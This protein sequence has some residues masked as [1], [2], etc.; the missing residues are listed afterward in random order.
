MP[1]NPA[2][3]RLALLSLLLLPPALQAVQCEVSTTSFALGRVPQSPMPSEMQSG[4]IE[5]SCFA[6]TADFTALPPSS[7]FTVNYLV[8]LS[9]SNGSF[10]ESVANRGL[11]SELKNAK[12]GYEVRAAAGC[13]SGGVMGYAG[14]DGVGC[15]GSFMFQLSPQNAVMGQTP[16][17]RATLMTQLQL[18]P[19]F[20]VPPASDYRDQL[21]VRLTY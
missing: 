15:P 5:V 11:R 12:L 9:G 3:S 19:S 1:R 14:G 18:G 13:G 20:A 7:T 6:E 10:V 4:S 17:Q 8:E 2:L 16:P 21:V